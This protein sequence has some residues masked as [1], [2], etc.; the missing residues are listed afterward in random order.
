[1]VAARWASLSEYHAVVKMPQVVDQAGICDNT[2]IQGSIFP[3]QLLI[4]CSEDLKSLFMKQVISSNKKVVKSS[5]CTSW[6]FG[7]YT[8]LETSI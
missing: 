1:M 5:P 4:N 6:I 3:P 8:S 7:T 2:I